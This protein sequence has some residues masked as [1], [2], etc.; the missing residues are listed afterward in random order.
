MY[1][2]RI[3][4]QQTL[5]KISG[6]STVTTFPRS[7]LVYFSF[8]RTQEARMFTGITQTL[9]VSQIRIWNI[10]PHITELEHQG[11]ANNLLRLCVKHRLPQGAQT[12]AARLPGQLNFAWCSLIFVGPPHGICF[13]SDIWHLQF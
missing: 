7:V 10:T 13:M 2:Q 6:S 8:L 1:F 12:P 4:N 11:V 3:I 9:Q 5:Q